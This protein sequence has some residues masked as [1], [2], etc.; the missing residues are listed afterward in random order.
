M[1]WK[2]ITVNTDSA[3]LDELAQL[4][5]GAG[6]DGLVIEDEKDFTD[7][8]ENNRQYWDY[9][10]EELMREKRGLSRI[11]FYLSDDAGGE[12]ALSG[13]KKLL[14]E[15]GSFKD[16][17]ISEAPVADEDWEENW[18]QYYKPTEVG[19]R[20]I[21][22]PEWETLPGSAERTVLRLDPGLMFGTGTH[23]TTRMCLENLEKYAGAGRSALDLGCGSG[24]LGIA[25]LLLGCTGA[26]GCDID[27][28]APSVVAENAAMNGI[29]PDMLKVYVG[30]ITS[31]AGLRAK[32]S[33]K[34]DIVLANIVAD[35]IINLSSC[36]KRFMAPGGV[37]ICSGI[38][39]GR[40]QET[41]SAI[42]AGGLTPTGHYH[43][44]NWHCF[45]AVI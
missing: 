29:T 41:E 30:D 45:T 24:I 17:E 13:I 36:V 27:E 2:E 22:V 20:L 10:D 34:Y 12:A 8:M 9:V 5:E 28:K 44:E 14:G 37:F 11:K 23:P 6:V 16:C 21:I 31:D 32:L 40:E 1:K 26:V 3:L 33:G 35:V 43:C 7:F 25:A 39:D 42:K 18:K 19:E 15:S 4:L 38:I